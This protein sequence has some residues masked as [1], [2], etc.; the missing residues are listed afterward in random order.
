VK[1]RPILLDTCAT[2]W[3]ANRSYLLD[4][5]L[6]ELDAVQGEAGGVVVSP[7]TAWEIGRLVALGRL[8][9]TLDTATWFEAVLAAGI[10]L[11][12]MTPDVL[13]ASAF[14]PGPF[15]R[16]PADRILAATARAFGYRLMTR[17][18]ALLDYAAKG[19]LMA[20]PC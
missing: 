11:A 10:K 9:L 15:L 6:S 7:I 12:D 4:S 5:A 20:L 17:D 1:G 16:D 13:L 3:L 14:L 8:V 2:I 19:H 18:G